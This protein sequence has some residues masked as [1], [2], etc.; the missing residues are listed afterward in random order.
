[1]S[2][3][4]KVKNITVVVGIFAVFL[5]VSACYLFQQNTGTDEQMNEPFSEIVDV[6]VQKEKTETSAVEGEKT[7]T[8]VT[9]ESSK[10]QANAETQTKPSEKARI[11]AA[12]EKKTTPPASAS[13]PVTP[14]VSKT[15]AEMTMQVESD[16]K[17]M[18]ICS[19]TV[20]CDTILNNIENVA[21]EKIQLIPENGAFLDDVELEFS[22]GDTVFDVLEKEMKNRKMHFEF[23]NALMYDSVY[24]E[25]IGNLYE[26]DAGGLSGWIYRVNGKVPTVGCSQY[27]LKN[28]DKIEVLYTCNMGRDLK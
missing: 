8:P 28:G 27:K 9:A 21:P 26:F 23:S 3:I 1:M 2:F 13:A 17:S 11:A 24:I 12:E 4:K 7:S 19:L 20:R 18:L 5:T 25:G 6:S 14:E 10:T 15:Q 16:E 22:E